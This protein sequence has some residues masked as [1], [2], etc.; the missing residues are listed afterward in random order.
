MDLVDD[1]LPDRSKEQL[2]INLGKI[3]FIREV[4]EQFVK[5][6]TKKLIALAV[7]FA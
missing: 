4:E 1:G 3:D 5:E 6:M 7:T 2:E